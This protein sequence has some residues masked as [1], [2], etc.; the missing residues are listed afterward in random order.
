MEENGSGKLVK[1]LRILHRFSI[2]GPS[3]NAFFLTAHLGAGYECK[4]VTGVL[5]DGE[6]S[7]DFLLSQ[8]NEQPTLL[9]ALQRSISPS[10][11]LQ[12]Y[13][14][15]RKII[16]EYKPDIV[17]THAAKPGTIG[18]LA[19][20]HENVPVIVHTFHG[21]VFHSYFNKWKT[22]FFIIIERLLAK[23][24]SAIIAISD[25]QKFDLTSRYKIAVDQ[26]VSV[27]P[28]GFDF[29]RLQDANGSKRHL[30]R[31]TFSVSDDTVV[32]MIIGRITEI[33]N[34]RMFVD[35]VSSAVKSGGPRIQAF[36][37]GDGE[38]RQEVYEHAIANGL[39][40]TCA[41]DYQPGAD[42]VF[43]S[44]RSDIECLI[45]GSDIVVLTSNN[46]GTPVSLIE[47]QAAGKVVVATNVGG[48]ADCLA[49]KNRENMVAKGDVQAMKE[50]ICAICSNPALLTVNAEAIRQFVLHRYSYTRLVNDVRNLYSKL[51]KISGKQYEG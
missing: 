37:V 3:H 15:I 26:K 8:L 18:R 7:A 27:I 19:A 16:R 22:N 24:T 45:N 17:H 29:K 12:A 5:E 42:L 2:S 40:V 6:T 35:V 44:W 28:L 41:A 13:K 30:F 50:K 49:P 1:V 11:D 43:T 46:E 48:V 34:H 14:Q 23:R 31:N 47:A 38:L 4:L 32:L 10:K 36:I 21:H 51:L 9:N 39:K 25:S 20:L 33:K